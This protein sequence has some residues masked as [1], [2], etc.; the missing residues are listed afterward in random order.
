MQKENPT[1]VELSRFKIVRF[2]RIKS[3]F[4]FYM[5][6]VALYGGKVAMRKI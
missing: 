4:C 5:L 1:I 6:L 3:T 2:G